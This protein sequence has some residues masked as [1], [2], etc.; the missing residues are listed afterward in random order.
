MKFI[1]FFSND[2]YLDGSY[3]LP[4]QKKLITSSQFLRIFNKEIIN[5]LFN[6]FKK[7]DY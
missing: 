3:L 7:I 4:F 6:K 2:F 1:N 5:Q